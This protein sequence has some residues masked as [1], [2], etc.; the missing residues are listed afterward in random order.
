M[1][2]FASAGNSEICRVDHRL[3]TGFEALVLRESFSPSESLTFLFFRTSTDWMRHTHVIKVHPLYLQVSLVAQSVKNL[4]A[5]QETRVRSLGRSPGKG[6][7][8]P[9]QYPCLE[10]LMDR[11]A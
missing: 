10:N 11:E 6:N 7:G 2:A 4:P 5:V 8:K 1:N 9:L 3:E